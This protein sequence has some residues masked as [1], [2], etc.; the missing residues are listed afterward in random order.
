MGNGIEIAEPLMTLNARGT[1]L[2]TQRQRSEPRWT[3]IICGCSTRG[4]LE[5]G[6]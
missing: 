4:T 6:A 2:F 5:M 1:Y 3:F